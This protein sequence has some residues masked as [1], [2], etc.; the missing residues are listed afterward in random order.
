M[1]A[2]D[3]YLTEKNL[4]PVDARD[5]EPLIYWLSV[6]SDPNRDPKRDGGM[7][8]FSSPKGLF[9][10][11]YAE[12]ADRQ[13]SWLNRVT[14]VGQVAVG[15][16]LLD[17]QFEVS[18]HSELAD[19]GSGS[20]P[21]F[22]CRKFAVDAAAGTMTELGIENPPSL[23]LDPNNSVDSGEI[24]GLVAG[25][26]R[27]VAQGDPKHDPVV[28]STAFNLFIDMAARRHKVGQDVLAAFC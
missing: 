3:A 6:V 14:I 1:V 10:A 12:A 20:D 5:Q 13:R 21:E 22:G 23:R 28:S 17:D 24:R 19:G 26:V 25:A 8:Y 2:N 27:E 4:L 18:L 11:I 9:Y 7:T 15:G 16:Q